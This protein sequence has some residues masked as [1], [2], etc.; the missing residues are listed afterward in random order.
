MNDKNRRD[1][2]ERL[3]SELMRVNDRSR[4]SLREELER[5]EQ[6]RN[7]LRAELTQ[8][9]PRV[10]RLEAQQRSTQ[11]AVPVPEAPRQ[12]ISKERAAAQLNASRTVGVVI[13]LT[14]FALFILWF[15]LV[16]R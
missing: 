2:L 11:V 13:V 9:A 7:R 4:I 10:A 14:M 16:H 3:Q 12:T 1:E 6:R 8:L 5:E 15:A